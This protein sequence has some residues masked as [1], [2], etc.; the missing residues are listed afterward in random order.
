[1]TLQAYKF[2][3]MTKNKRRSEKEPG[4]DIVFSLC[5]MQRPIRDFVGFVNKLSN[6]TNTVFIIL[7]KKKK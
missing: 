5:N 6:F 2:C 7:Y 4:A 1:M 3:A